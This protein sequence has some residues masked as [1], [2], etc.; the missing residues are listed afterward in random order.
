MCFVSETA[1]DHWKGFTWLLLIMTTLLPYLFF[2]FCRNQKAFRCLYWGFVEIRDH[3]QPDVTEGR[4][5]A[6]YNFKT[7]KNNIFTCGICVSG[8][9][10]AT[11]EITEEPFCH[12]NIIWLCT[13]CC[14]DNIYKHNDMSVSGARKNSYQYKESLSFWTLPGL[15]QFFHSRK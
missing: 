2:V 8:M 5:V 7:K 10:K 14:Q 6:T 1:T 4:L 13:E 9:D 12:Q 15:S 11:S 3:S